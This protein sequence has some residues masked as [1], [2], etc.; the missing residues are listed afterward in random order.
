MELQRRSFLK[1]LSLCVGGACAGGGA[2]DDD[3][4]APE[5]PILVGPSPESEV[6]DM[7]VFP[8]GVMAGDMEATSATAARAIL[9]TRCTS[10]RAPRL[11]VWEQATNRIVFDGTAAIKEGG[12]VHHDVATLRPGL[13]YGYQ[14]RVEIGD[15]PPAY[16]SAGAL[17]TPPAPGTRPVVTFGAVSCTHQAGPAGFQAVGHAASQELDCFFHLGDHVYNDSRTWLKTL[18]EFRASWKECFDLPYMRRFHG[19]HGVYFTWDDHEII[20][21]WDWDWI[22]A[23]PTYR[24]SVQYGTQTY[25]EHHPLRRNAVDPT[26]LW[27][28]VKWG[29]TAELFILDLR[30]ERREDVNRHMISRAQMDWL[31]RGLAQSTAVFKFVMNPIPVCTMPPED[32][33]VADRWEGFA[34]ERDELLGWIRDQHLQGVWWI[35]GDYHVGAVGQIEQYGYRWY[36]MREVMMGPGAGHGAAEAQSM[37]A[38]TDA[39]SGEKQWPFTT[40]ASNYVT[41]TADPTARTVRVRFYNGANAVIHDQ[42]YAAD[43]KPAGRTVPAVLATKYAQVKPILGEPLTHAHGTYDGAGTWQQFQ[44]GYLY[45]HPSTTAHELHGRILDYWADQGWSQSWLGYPVTD[46][47]VTAAGDEEQEF[48]LGWITKNRTTGA[49]TTRAK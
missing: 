44:Y 37:A 1:Y 23:N 21:N 40:D 13:R 49:I 6:I 19:K 45:S 24:P 46:T 18:A 35:S 20:N 27:R 29:D 31:K 8:F 9:W 26:R 47:Y 38:Y 28:S 16:S 41:I 33:H 39:T 17:K 43:Y 7:A 32:A 4:A 42:T 14:F 3:L 12:F 15:A 25:F 22:D 48:Q 36:G 34:P 11:V 2:G 5:S 30:G 10:T